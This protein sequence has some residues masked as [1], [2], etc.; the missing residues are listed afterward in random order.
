[1]VLEQTSPGMTISNERH[2]V[3]PIDE[4]RD[5]A[6]TIQL[7]ALND[8]VDHMEERLDKIVELIRGI[9]LQGRRDRDREDGR[10]VG[11]SQEW[12]FNCQD[13]VPLYR[14]QV[15]EE[16]SSDKEHYIANSNPWVHQN[17]SPDKFRL[18]VDVLAFSN[19]LEIGDFLDWIAEIKKFFNYVDIPEEKQVKLIAYK[20]KS[21]ASL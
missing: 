10:G 6:T 12:R 2:D 1:M 4:V 18:K 16:T 19:N 3:N 17:R 20:L 8:W 14:N 5:F 11:F 15:Y 21:G 13:H 9:G 7:Q